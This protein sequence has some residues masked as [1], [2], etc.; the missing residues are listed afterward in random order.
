VKSVNN[1]IKYLYSTLAFCLLILFTNCTK[2]LPIYTEVYRNAFDNGQSDIRVYKGDYIDSSK[3]N[4]FFINNHILGP[5]N[6]N[7]VYKDLINLPKHKLLKITF[8]LYIH[9]QWKG[10][11]NLASDFWGLFIDKKRDFYTTFSN[12]PGT[13]QAYP[14]QEGYYFP[15]GSN[16]FN[17]NLPGRCS[18]SKNNYG[19]SVYQF[20][21]L[22][23]HSNSSIEIALS[24]LVRENNS[25]IK[26]WSIDNL[27]VTCIDYEN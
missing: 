19:T 24:D 16:A 14:E 4:L 13:K 22:K 5:L 12:L 21:W 18:L 25:C 9:D 20:T 11:D 2:N 27:I 23:A 3:F 8:D 7:T 10:N 6:H 1:K 17:I 26:S 15:P